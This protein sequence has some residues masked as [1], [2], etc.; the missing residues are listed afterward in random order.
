M[1]YKSTAQF[2]SVKNTELHL[3]QTNI[4]NVTCRT[5]N[6]IDKILEEGVHYTL[7]KINGKATLIDDIDSSHV[8]FEFEH[9]NDP[10][11]LPTPYDVG[12]DAE[13]QEGRTKVQNAISILRGY[14]N[15]SSP[16]QLQTVTTL[17]VLIRLVLLL[18]RK[19]L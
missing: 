5:L 17:K 19:F 16:S 1:K 4:D 9:N 18:I 14:L 8:M 2:D 6:G 12:N 7:D 11:P 10:T 3:A 15:N 13:D